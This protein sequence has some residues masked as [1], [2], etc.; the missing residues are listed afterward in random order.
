VTRCAARWAI[1]IGLAMILSPSPLLAQDSQGTDVHFEGPFTLRADELE[2]RSADR[3]YLARG[4]VEIE[5]EGRL[6][7]ADSVFFD[8][9]T[10]LGV[11]TGHVEITERGDTLKSSFLH[12]DVDTLHGTVFD[13]ELIAADSSF[14]MTGSEIE[15]TGEKTYTVTD[16]RFTTCQCPEDARRDPWALRAATA[17]LEIDGYAVAKNSRFEVLDVPMLWLPWFA[18]PIKDKRTTGFLVPEAGRSSRA[19]FDVAVPFFWAVR[20]N[21]N[22]T[23]TSQY[24]TKRGFKPGADLEYVFGQRSYGELYGTFINDKD[25]DED[26]SH[27]E[28]FSTNRWGADWRHLQDLPA[29]MRLHIDA[30]GTSDNNFPFD[31]DD[32]SEYRLERYLHSRAF[33][34]TSFGPNDRFLGSTG[35]RFADDL[36]SPDRDDRDDFILQR[37]PEVH[38]SALSGAV[39]LVPGL[40]ASGNVDYSWFQPFRDP[41]DLYDQSLLVND[42]F[43]DTGLDAIPTGKERNS[44][45]MRVPFDINEDDGVTE[46]DGS[47][48]EGEPLADKGHR[49]L[50]NPRLSYPVH[51][52]FLHFVPEVGYHGT[53]YDSDLSGTE[54]RNLLTGT[55]DLRTQFT[56]T[57]SWPFSKGDAEHLLE[58]FLS[59]AFVSDT[60]QRDNPLFVPAT[61]V[62]QKRLRHIDLDNLTRDSADRIEEVNSVFAGAHNRF[63]NPKTRK[64]I[65]EVVLSVEY[66]ID[67]SE[68]GTVVV[69]GDATPG[70]GL[71]TRFHAVY[72]TPDQEIGEG[73]LNF[74]WSSTRGDSV[75]LRYRYVRQIPQVFE[76]FQD[77]DNRFDDFEGDF[78]R[79][80]QVTGGFDLKANERWAFTYSGNYSFENALSLRNV[81]GVEYVS[82]CKCWAFRFEGS[83]QRQRGFD[84][85]F[86]YR[87]MG[88]GDP[89]QRPFGGSG[90]NPFVRR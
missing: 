63:L 44:E 19:G 73:L 69:Q 10:R 16:G 80:S 28:N 13:G 81:A 88:L 22:L 34:A 68:V 82:R 56:R 15:K 85:A 51:W 62:P 76:D 66:D 46:I 48:Q 40:V 27:D 74:T 52:E 4:N 39:P 36:Q 14:T 33:L 41:D 1:L 8:D 2:V 17:D 90:N 57:I 61:S 59:Y 84:F 12:F 25:V 45:G 6:L 64:E 29:D 71:R 50:L 43:Y 9:T 35:V 58:P 37:L 60:G 89:K 86:R 83:H 18:Y 24:Q 78:R 42:Q 47:F 21:V 70:S 53:L 55:A 65:A 49:I 67:E 79:I 11:A 38:L 77:D 31:F 54:T 5:Q 32:F 72:D 23:L 7:T 20:D 30:V 87:L 3:V 26:E 75:A